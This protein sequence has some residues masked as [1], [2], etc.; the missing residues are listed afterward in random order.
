[1]LFTYFTLDHIM[2]FKPYITK[3]VDMFKDAHYHYI[4]VKKVRFADDTQFTSSSQAAESFLTE[5]SKKRYPN[6]FTNLIFQEKI[7]MDIVLIFTTVIPKLF[8]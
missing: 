3:V 8:Q 4:G 1:M 2:Q 6:F 5:A 7:T